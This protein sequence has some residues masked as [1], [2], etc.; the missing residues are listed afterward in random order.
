MRHAAPKR[1]KKRNMLTAFIGGGLLLFLL[2]T[3]GGDRR[4]LEGGAEAA[5]DDTALAAKVQGDTV[6]VHSSEPVTAPDLLEP[7]SQEAAETIRPGAEPGELRQSASY[8]VPATDRVGER[9]FRDALF[10]GDSRVMG[11]MLYS[12]L[13]EATF[14]TEKG[15]NVKTLLTKPIVP[16]TGGGKLTVLQALEQQQFGKIYIK[17]GLNELG[18]AYPSSFIE[19]YAEAIDQIRALQ[20][21]AVFYVQSILPVS[22]EKDAGDNVFTNQRIAEFN[23]LI[24]EMAWEKGLQYLDATEWFTDDQGCLPEEA[25]HDGIHLNKEY[26]KV[27][28]DF[29]KRHTLRDYAKV[30]L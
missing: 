23:N 6:I 7:S 11:L 18:W 13:T 15:I 3:G 26:C 16:Q 4:A 9:Y 8:H 2:F 25:G 28:L 30:R 17:I 10:I 24:Q 29:L 1:T 27:W 5:A 14:Y 20:P 19:A 21:E 22:A 12:G